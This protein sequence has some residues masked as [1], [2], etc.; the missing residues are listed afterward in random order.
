[1]RSLITDGGMALRKTKSISKD[2]YGYL[3]IAPFCIAFLL[4][5]LYPIL[6]TFWASFLEWDGLTE[7]T[8]M[9][10]DNYKRLFQDELFLGSII[11]TIIISLPAMLLQIITGLVL[12]FIMNQP[13]FRGSTIFKVIYYFPGLV[14]AISLSM[15]FSLLFDWQV[16]AANRILISLDLINKPIHWAMNARFSRGIIT[17]IL[18]FQFFGNYTILFTAGIKGIS[19]DILEAAQI[20]GAGH[21]K[22]F[23]RITLPLLRPIII[24]VTIISI[25]GSLQIFDINYVIGGVNGD[26]AHTTLSMSVYMYAQTFKNRN[27]G[28]GAAISYGIFLLILIFSILYMRFTMKEEGNYQ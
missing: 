3:F 22:I 5:K 4:F 25:I 19:S 28:Y 20:D 15:L 9:G 18:W 12:A 8:F 27:F 26:P 14:T 10:F 13:K 11:N 17:F 1:M 24:Y 23:S 21:F 7:P 2:N 16:G 6:Y